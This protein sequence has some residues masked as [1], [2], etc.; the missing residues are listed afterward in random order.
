MSSSSGGQAGAAPLSPSALLPS[1]NGELP[2]LPPLPPGTSAFDGD[3]GAVI[4][5][6]LVTARGFTCAKIAHHLGL[7]PLVVEACVRNGES[8]PA[9]RAQLGQWLEEDNRLLSTVPPFLAASL[10][11][12]CLGDELAQQHRA[13]QRQ[14]AAG[15]TRRADPDED[16]ADELSLFNALD[17]VSRQHFRTLQ[18]SVGQS[19]I[20]ILNDPTE[21]GEPAAWGSWL[22]GKLYDAFD[23]GARTSSGGVEEALRQLRLR[24][25][26]DPESSASLLL[27]HPPQS[28]FS[29]YVKTVAAAYNTNRKE[30]QEIRGTTFSMRRAAPEE[31]PWPASVPAEFF[32]PS[33]RTQPEVEQ[34]LPPLPTTE[35][36]SMLLLP[37]TSTGAAA[38]DYSALERVKVVGPGTFRRDFEVLEERNKALRG[39]E[40]EVEQCLMQHVQSRSE[41]F[42]A[43]SRGFTQL[44]EQGTEAMLT[45]T[46]TRAGDIAKSAASIHELLSIG[47][48]YRREKNFEAV[49][50]LMGRAIRVFRHLQEIDNWAALPERDV[51]ELLSVAAQ[52]LE[53]ESFLRSSGDGGSAA[54]PFDSW[55]LM[56]RLR[57][58]REVPRRTAAARRSVEAVVQEEA[59][60]RLSSDLSDAAQ[61][62]RAARA[63]EAA[64]LL[65][66]LETALL[67]HQTVVV[68]SQWSVARESVVAFLMS[69]GTLDD[70]KANALLTESTTEAAMAEPAN[71]EKKALLA[72]TNDCRFSVFVSLLSQLTDCLAQE[73]GTVAQN[74]GFALS[75]CFPPALAMYGDTAVLAQRS[76]RALLGS[77]C[78]HAESVIALLIEIRSGTKVITGAQEV[79]MIARQG[80]AFLSVVLNP[81]RELAAVSSLSLASLVDGGNS[82]IRVG[83]QLRAAVHKLAKRFLR[84]QHSRNMEKLQMI[85]ESE[86][87][88]PKEGID[89]VFQ[90]HVEELC[91]SDAAAIAT[92]ESTSVE[93]VHQNCEDAGEARGRPNRRPAT[94]AAPTKQDDVDADLLNVKAGK[95]YLSLDGEGDGRT[96][97]DSLLLL[98]ELLSDY[99]DLLAKFP[100]LAFDVVSRLYELVALYDSLCAEM[101]LGGRATSK[102]SLKSITTAHLCVASQCCAFLTDFIPALQARLI[103]VLHVND[104]DSKDNDGDAPASPPARAAYV[105]A[106]ARKLLPFISNDLGRVAADCRAH[107]DE[108][109]VKMA[110]LVL[111]KVDS[112]GAMDAPGEWTA[113]GNEWVMTM[114]REVARL[115]RTLRPMLPSA[116]LRGVVVP[117]LGSLAL[118]IRALSCRIAQTATDARSMATSDVLLFK[119]NVECFGFDVLRC[120]SL[121]AVSTAMSARDLEPATS[122]QDALAWFLSPSALSPQTGPSG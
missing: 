81:V 94:A 48:L 120:A 113:R 7:P 27:H 75:E 20:S 34:L 26:T 41:D 67:S 63:L 119:L 15:R 100:S 12:A 89:P 66:V 9:L 103:A 77:V 11:E 118:K 110:T 33:R 85:V 36:L 4:C 17:P 56:S 13:R 76:S 91:Q 65:G 73:I 23:Y 5:A 102:G 45:A 69:S 74:W 31:V 40:G 92:F 24:E 114:L 64:A 95:L 79:E 22:G 46:A 83:G 29:D 109:F 122:D 84:N 39:W 68:R 121:T 44:S 58:M 30:S 47:A 57:L 38:G 116:D 35:D 70:A 105:S 32:Q 43:A 14:G 50:A 60:L 1:N 82:S 37:S 25:Q 10:H 21:C 78:A 111:N 101:V 98:V 96:V 115:M 6:Y 54:A 86:T 28:D 88:A 42:F 8:S 19:F 117:L 72:Y 59:V 80:F 52:L 108:F 62:P 3:G 93:T 104:N 16:D 90:T 99:D 2:P 49:N 61:W 53:L 18:D 97:G 106:S 71:D 87:W 55:A 51:T 107:R 112:L